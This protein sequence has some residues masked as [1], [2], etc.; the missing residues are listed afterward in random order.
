M[1]DR[2]TVLFVCLHNANRS[3]IAAGWLQ[4]L[5]GDQVEVRSAG[6]QPSEQVSPAA[7]EAMAEAGID[8]S[9]SR[10]RLLI[11]EDLRAADVVVTLG[12]ADACP[13]VPGT[14]YEDWALGRGQG[15]ALDQA[16]A[17]RDQ[18]EQRVGVLAADLLGS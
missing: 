4:Q 11:D 3:Q 12:C 2:P 1:T 7:V 9:G 5:A 6:P 13:V 14:R 10:P 17:V 8:I 18:I 15:D 16:R